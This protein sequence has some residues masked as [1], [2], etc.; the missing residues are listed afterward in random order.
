MPGGGMEAA[1]SLTITFSQSSA[2][3]SGLAGSADS[4]ERPPVRSFWL[5]H[6]TQYWLR[7]A[8]ASGT[9]AVCARETGARTVPQS[10]RAAA[11]WRGCLRADD[12]I[13]ASEEK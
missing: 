1:R 13:G 3:A 6:T 12:G 9:G 8:R 10:R 7:T 2:L 5:W 4:S 11:V